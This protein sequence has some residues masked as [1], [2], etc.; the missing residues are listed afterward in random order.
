MFKLKRVFEGYFLFTLLAVVAV[1]IAG[2]AEEGLF[3]RLVP[4]KKP[5]IHVPAEQPRTIQKDPTVRIPTQ[6]TAT[7]F[8]QEGNPRPEYPT[9]ARQRKMEGE[10]ILSAV[11]D[12]EG[13]TSKV[14]VM[15]SSGHR[16]LD[17]AAVEA[18]KQAKYWTTSTLQKIKKKY[19]FRLTDEDHP[20]SGFTSL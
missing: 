9:E 11:V 3:V 4:R 16:I 1:W 15:K 19:V 18:E 13:T 17:E 12:A 5:R 7:I 8:E 6:R 14:R 20:S 2:Q 10:V